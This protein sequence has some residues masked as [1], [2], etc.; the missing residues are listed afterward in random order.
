MEERD[1]RRWSSA[2][3]DVGTSSTVIPIKQDRSG[4]LPG[5]TG[6]V[7]GRLLIWFRVETRQFIQNNSTPHVAHR[8]Y[9]C[10]RLKHDQFRAFAT[11][12]KL[13]VFQKRHFV[14]QSMF[15]VRD[16]VNS[17]FRYSLPCSVH[18]F[19]VQLN[20][21]EERG[22]MLVYGTPTLECDKLYGVAGPSSEG[23]KPLDA[24]LV[25]KADFRCSRGGS[26]YVAM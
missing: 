6:R 5:A 26:N 1:L 10:D 7:L 25:G 17:T 11:T 8:W 18:G 12:R 4:V 16:S 20:S 3:I 24:P 9:K 21:V 14:R 22:I 2:Y 23:T 15:T 19:P 13:L